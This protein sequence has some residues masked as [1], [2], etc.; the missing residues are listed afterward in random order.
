MNISKFADGHQAQPLANTLTLIPGGTRGIGLATAKLFA[1][2]GSRVVVL[3][4]DQERI[5]YVLEKELGPIHGNNSSVEHLGFQCDVSNQ[6]D[7]ERT[8]KVCCVFG[9]LSRSFS[10]SS[11]SEHLGTLLTLLPLRKEREMATT[12][13]SWTLFFTE[14]DGDGTKNEGCIWRQK[15]KKR[16][17]GHQEVLQDEGQDLLGHVLIAWHWTVYGI[18]KKPRQLN[19]CS[20]IVYWFSLIRSAGNFTALSLL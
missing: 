10:N 4:R 20:I 6:E 17:G 13:P 3:G 9:F 8:I 12:T 14:E 1:R 16:E 19:G 11:S 15:G 7:I 18:I 5:K 2:N